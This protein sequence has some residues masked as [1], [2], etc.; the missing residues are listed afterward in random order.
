[1]PTLHSMRARVLALS[2]VV[3]ACAGGPAGPFVEQDVCEAAQALRRTP[4]FTTVAEEADVAA[5]VLPGGFG[6]LYQDIGHGLVAYF[7]GP[8]DFSVKQELVKLLQCG[9]AYPGWAGV[10]VATDAAAVTVL[11]GRYSAIELL[12]WLR[13][14]EPLK[15]DPV[16]WGL[17]VDQ[18]ANRIWLGITDADQLG[19]IQQAVAARPIA[20]AAV[21]IEVPPPTTGLE[22]FE[23]LDPLLTPS[24]A[25]AQ[26]TF[27]FQPRVRFTN[28]QSS[29]R[30]PDWC[31]GV[32]WSF[33]LGT[34]EK[35]YGAGWRPV[36][37]FVCTAILLPPR[38]VQPGESVT[39][40]IPVVGVRR[41]S[42]GPAWLTARITGTYRF[43][44]RVYAATM[45]NPAGGTPLLTD[46]APQQEQIST[47][48]RLINTLPF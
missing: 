4:D 37:G 33:F 46:L 16:V 14:L 11:Q 15:A 34:I 47:P 39:D 27:S 30:Y 21:Q 32:E 9:G 13:A 8:V 40:V 26:G 10:L 42:G 29:T 43:V 41:L 1:M 31:G 28:R 18:E 25:P 17:E 19:R 45:A 23:I 24:N 44:G 36:S 35:W 2:A 6:G 22:Q 3:A 12:S 7:K 20:F 5:R 38:A 48:F